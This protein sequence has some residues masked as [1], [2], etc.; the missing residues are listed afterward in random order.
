MCYIQLSERNL[1]Q[2]GHAL[3]YGLNFVPLLKFTCRSPNP[4]GMVF[5]GGNFGK[6]LG[7]DEVVSVGPRMGLVSLQEEETG[8]L[9][10]T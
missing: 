10:T 6:K 5:G 1:K 3:C 7:L 4:R 9:C 2:Q 8:S